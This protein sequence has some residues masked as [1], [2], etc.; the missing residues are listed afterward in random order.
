MWVHHWG[1]TTEP[2]ESTGLDAFIADEVKARISVARGVTVTS[3]AEALNIRRGALSAR[4]N[5]RV[6]FSSQMLD[7]VALHLGA[8]VSEIVAAAERR[9]SQEAGAGRLVPGEAQGV[10]R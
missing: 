5:G 10:A 8:S 1:M 4:V 2:N 9:R 3:A 6:P 7:R